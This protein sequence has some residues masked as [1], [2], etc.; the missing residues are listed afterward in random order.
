MRL[1]HIFQIQSILDGRV[2]PSDIAEFLE[3][4]YFSESKDREIKYGDM[5][6]T[7]V[8][9]VFMNK[10]NLED[11]IDSKISIGSLLKL[12]KDKMN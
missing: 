9:R 10:D 8:I 4:K 2:I 7:H 1:K 11:I 5:D 6:I 12:I 3:Q